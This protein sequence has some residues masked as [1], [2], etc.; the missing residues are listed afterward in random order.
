[1]LGFYGADDTRISATVPDLAQAMARA[2]VAFEHHIYPGAP[3][4]FFNDTR[5][6]YRA[7]AARDA[8]ARCLTFFAAHLAGT[9]A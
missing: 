9:E 1:V 7:G 6:S 5:R 8:W 2:G 3:H 4:A